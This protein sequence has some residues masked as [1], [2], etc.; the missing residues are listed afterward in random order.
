MR[1]AI[2]P[3]RLLLIALAGSLNQPPARRDRVLQ[4]ENRVLREQRGSKQVRFSDNEV[5][6]L[7]VKNSTEIGPN[8]ARVL[9][10]VET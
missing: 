5:G 7:V 3:F 1:L 9:K 4:E 10:F 6:C 2:D 8:A